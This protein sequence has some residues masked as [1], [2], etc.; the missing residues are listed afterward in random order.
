[1]RIFAQKFVF[2]L[3]ILLIIIAG[4]W[5]WSFIKFRKRVAYFTAMTGLLKKDITPF[6]DPSS[7]LRLASALT[8]IQQYKDA[9]E[10]YEE[11]LS[12][13]TFVPNR[14]EIMT[15][16]EFCKS[17]VPGITEAKNI[18]YSWWHNFILLRLGR[19]RFNFLTEEDYLNTNSFLRNY[20][21]G[22]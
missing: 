9:S 1:M 11:L 17:P 3:Y 13:G 14:T 22:R 16:L 18:N 15:N 12:S 2:M 8:E 10:I 21:S 4:M 20:M 5:I 19:K 7:K 6:S